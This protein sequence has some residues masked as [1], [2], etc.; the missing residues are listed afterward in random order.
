MYHGSK[1][2]HRTKDCPIFLE[3]KEKNEEEFRKTFAA[4]NTQRS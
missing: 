3:S 1:T 4:I 2:D